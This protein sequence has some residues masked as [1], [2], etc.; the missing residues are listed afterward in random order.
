MGC[1][2]L[3][4]D[5][6]TA[7]WNVGPAGYSSAEPNQWNGPWGWFRWAGVAYSPPAHFWYSNGKGQFLL[8]GAEGLGAKSDPNEIQRTV[9]PAVTTQEPW[10]LKD[11]Q[12][13]RFRLTLPVFIEGKR[14]SSGEIISSLPG[15][16][17]QWR[18]FVD[19]ELVKYAPGLMASTIQQ[20]M[21]P[22]TV[23]A[24]NLKR[25]S[26]FADEEQRNSN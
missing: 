13:A 2:P 14:Y 18:Y 9:P 6:L 17:G 10:E 5:A 12:V 4:S 20:G 3:T 8:K 15:P 11:I 25:L 16:K 1:D 22:L 19:G 24:R 23:G 26:F 7:K 21:I